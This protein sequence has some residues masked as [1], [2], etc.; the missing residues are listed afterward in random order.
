M[1]QAPWKEQGQNRSDADPTHTSISLARRLRLYLFV[2]T[3]ERSANPK[4]IPH[5]TLG[6]LVPARLPILLP[7]PPP[8][9]YFV[10]LLCA[11]AR[12]RDREKSNLNWFVDR[13]IDQVVVQNR[14]ADSTEDYL[15]IARDCCAHLRKGPAPPP[16]STPSSRMASRLGISTPKQQQQQQESSAKTASSSSPTKAL[17]PG[18]GSRSSSPTPGAGGGGGP[19]GGQP[20]GAAGAAAGA[21]EGASDGGGGGR[22]AVTVTEWD[23]GEPRGRELVSVLLF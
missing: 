2:A 9:P 7:P 17:K 13:S 23:L 5:P 10:S 15:N 4:M 14:R 20:G 1:V 12:N 8:S 6:A 19:G 21:G 18:G 22:P 3:R 11:L 16:S